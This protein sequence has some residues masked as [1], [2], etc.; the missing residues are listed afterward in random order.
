MSRWA[1][2][3]SAPKQTRSL[4][5]PDMDTPNFPLTSG[6][7]LSTQVQL[8]EHGYEN[9]ALKSLLAS[10]HA[11]G[12]QTFRVFRLGEMTLRMDPPLLIDRL[13]MRSDWGALDFAA[14][15]PGRIS[16]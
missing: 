1:F 4:E 3:V 10:A 9:A 14:I 15:T 8:S 16:R 2:I 6:L 11:T 12:D 13:A 5:L 7:N